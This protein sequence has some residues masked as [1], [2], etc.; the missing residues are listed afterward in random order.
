MN[1]GFLLR[2]QEVVN[3]ITVDKRTVD[4][5]MLDEQEKSNE[6]FAILL[7]ATQTVT[8]VRAE[9]IDPDRHSRFLNVFP[10]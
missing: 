2:F 1:S 8:H 5:G 3:H 4:I 9:A 6:E 10:Q 7:S